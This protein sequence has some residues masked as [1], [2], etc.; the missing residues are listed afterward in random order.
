MIFERWIFEMLWLCGII[1]LCFV[2]LLPFGAVALQLYCS[3]V[4]FTTPH[5]QMDIVDVDSIGV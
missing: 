2:A 4:A 1:A 3:C 5:L